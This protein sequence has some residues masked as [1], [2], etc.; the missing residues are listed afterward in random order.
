MADYPFGPPSSTE[1]GTIYVPPSG[2]TSGASD[3][4]SLNAALATGLR[5]GIS[6]SYTIDGP[7]L[8]VAGGALAGSGVTP[9]QITQKATT[10]NGI[11]LISSSPISD[12]TLSGFTLTGPGSGSGI[13]I[14]G[15][16]DSGAD[17]MY[18]MKISNVLV[19]G[20]GGDGIDLNNCFVS[21]LDQVTASSN[22]A[23]GFN[24]YQGTTLSLR[25][26][27]ANSNAADRGFYINDMESCTLVSCGADTNAIGY[28]FYQCIALA[29]ISCDASGTAA[30]SSGLDGSS[31]K[32][33]DCYQNCQAVSCY[34]N[35]NGAI[36]FYITG[37]SKDVTILG[38]AEANPAGGATYGLKV[39][40]GSTC[41]QMNSTFATTQ[42]GGSF[43]AIGG[44][45]AAYFGQG[46]ESGTG[47]VNMNGPAISQGS[48]APT[49]PGGTNPT[50]G[51]YYFRTDATGTSDERLY[52]CTVGG[53]SPTWVGIV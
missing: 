6:G 48:G 28:E 36:G 8:G 46:L 2:D 37:S 47:R 39:D 50:A 29:A 27:R 17:S 4:A 43:T 15:S 44:G 35:Q 32:F 12:V 23:K 40:S 7:L 10:A 14:Y 13:G 41:V 9:T 11:S 52:V 5:V 45:S 33:N 42:S 49:T 31:L 18:R 34:V 19:T 25:G 21:I 16:A 26:C 22:G 24:F 38:C 1:L 20:M 51:D 53:A 30:G 3:L